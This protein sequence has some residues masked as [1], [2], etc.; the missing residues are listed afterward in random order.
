MKPFRPKLKLVHPQT[1]P[2]QTGLVVAERFSVSIGKT[3]LLKELD[4]QLVEKQLTCIIGPSGSGKSTL[5]RSLNRINDDIPTFTTAG[6]LSY[7][8]QDIYSP[9]MNPVELRRKIGMVFQKPCVFPQSIADNVLFGLQKKPYRKKDRAELSMQ[10]LKDVHLWEEVAHRLHDQADTLSIGQQQR[11]C[12]ARTIAIQPDLIMLDEPTSSLDPVST[13]AIESLLVELKTQH[14][15][16]LVTHNIQQARR[17]ADY[18]IFLCDGQ[19]VEQG[20]KD[21]IFNHPKQ[22]QTRNYLDNE[23]CDC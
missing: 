15:I 3:Q 13:L 12:I 10:P 11:L 21:D 2:T 16:L 8:G 22:S 23:L 9:E 1:Q 17:I 5:L 14:N 20:T 6:Q 19:I 4:F 7:A 18:I